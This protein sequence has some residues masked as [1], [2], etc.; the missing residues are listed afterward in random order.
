MNETSLT[1][2][3]HNRAQAWA[4]IGQ[5]MF[6]FLSQ[7]LQAGKKLV[8]VA[9][10]KKRTVKQNK[11]Y[12]GRGVL[13]QIAEQATTNGKLYKAELWHEYFKRKFIGVIELP[14]G[15]YEGESSTKLN[16][17]EFCAFSDQV[18]AYAVTELGVEFI[19]LPPRETAE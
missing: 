9:S 6:P 19:D 4:L 17:A 16:T 2:E 3:F 5:T 12:W 15:T 10:L 11:R 8:C 7:W 14:D 1:L 18:E 13:A